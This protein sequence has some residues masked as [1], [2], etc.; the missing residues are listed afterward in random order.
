ME[1]S[2]LLD[3][4]AHL[5]AAL[6][7]GSI[8]G[9]E[10]TFNGRPA[11]FRTH[12]LVCVA[13]ALLLVTTRYQ[14]HWL[15][16]FARD[17]VRTDPTRMSQGI[18]TGIGFLGAGVI[19]RDG[20]SVRGLTTAAS[21]WITA[22]IG[23]L[24]GLGL[25]VPAAMGTAI[26]FVTLSSFRVLETKMPTRH[27]VRCVVRCARAHRIPEARLRQLL[28]DHRC[29][30]ST[31]NYVLCGDGEMFEYHLLIRTIDPRHLAELSESLLREAD[32]REFRITSIAI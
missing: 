15:D 6:L 16:D 23:S 7:A 26:T 31:T 30:I 11:G 3:V 25:Y 17:T 22:A 19:F 18:M 2:L 8:I 13:S 28:A 27:F 21:I 9:L 14:Q 32:V 4:A 24:I 10:R 5:G 20:L 1:Q 29:S 12:V